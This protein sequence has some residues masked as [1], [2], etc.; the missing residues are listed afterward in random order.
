MIK[1][2]KTFMGAVPWC[3]PLM[4]AAMSPLTEEDMAAVTG[5]EGIALGLELRVNTDQDGNPFAGGANDYIDC[6]HASDPCR[7]ALNFDNIS[8]ADGSGTEVWLVFSGW[9]LAA[10]IDDIFLDA[11]EL[12]NANGGS[13]D[14]S[15]ADDRPATHNRFF[16]V[17]QQ[18]MLANCSSVSDV[19]ASILDMPALR[20]S[21]PSS[22]LNYN[23][24]SNR[25]SGFDNT[26]IT[27]NLEGAAALTADDGYS[28]SLNGSFLGARI[29]D[30]DPSN[31][32]AGWAFEGDVYVFGY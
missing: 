8:A 22:I 10:K 32:F 25:S 4:A 7:W 30:V 24:V 1:Y 6:N 21:T 20:I 9:S 29:N 31:N 5:R 3:L 15:M 19:T 26:L 17:D 18:C 13:P 16:N 12:K 14:I 11:G 2:R 23:S 27:L 28:S